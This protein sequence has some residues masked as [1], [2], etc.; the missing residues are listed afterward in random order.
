MRGAPPAKLD[1]DA[2]HLFR[3]DPPAVEQLNVT[4]ERLNVR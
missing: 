4:V 3:L 2:F 1:W